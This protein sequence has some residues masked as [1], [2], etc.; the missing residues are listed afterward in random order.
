[1]GEAKRKKLAGAHP[2][3]SERSERHAKIAL[4][5][6]SVI[7]PPLGTCFM[8]AVLSKLALVALKMPAEITIGSM[9]YRAGNDEFR[10]VVASAAPTTGLICAAIQ[11]LKQ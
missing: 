2:I 9:L 5:V 11:M 7:L 3:P 10:D 8:R 6:Q 4:S 1:M